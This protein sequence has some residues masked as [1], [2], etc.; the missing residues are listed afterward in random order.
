MAKISDKR[1]A[2]ALKAAHGVVSDAADR[3]GI[4]R[5]AVE[6]RI[7]ASVIVG[8]AFDEARET[9]LD[10]AEAELGKAVSKGAPWAIRYFLD[11]RGVDRGYGRRETLTVKAGID[12]HAKI[13]ESVGGEILERLKHGVA[14]A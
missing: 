12:L 4:P 14:D 10:T 8:R 2:E 6:R 3:L 5:H 9:I 1:I 13:D 7:K 11:N